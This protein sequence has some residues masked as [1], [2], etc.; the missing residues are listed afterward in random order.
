MHFYIKQC[1]VAALF[2]ASFIIASPGNA[3]APG[4]HTMTLTS[5]MGISHAFSVPKTVPS[6]LPISS[7]TP[8]SSTPIIV[9][10]PMT[11]PEEKPIV[12]DGT[13]QG[14]STE[15]DNKIKGWIKVLSAEPG[16][17]AWKKSSYVTSPLG[18]GTHAWLITLQ[19]GDK[20]TGY[21]IVSSDPEGKIELTEYG[22]GSSP[23]FS[24]ATLRDSLSQRGLLSK[25]PKYDTAA[26]RYYLG[27]LEAF[28]LIEIANKPYYFDAKSGEAL[29]DLTKLMPVQTQS[30]VDS[31]T[32][33]NPVPVEQPGKLVNATDRVT[34]QLLTEVFDPYDNAGWIID[35]PIL[36][37]DASTL[38]NLLRIDKK[39]TYTIKL[40]A[41]KALFPF[42]VRGTH[43]W[44]RGSS[45]FAVEQAGPRYVPFNRARAG[46][47]YASP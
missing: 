30:L 43:H 15:L 39:V 35:K 16:F 5:G 22:P 1:C 44:L 18:P 32:I 38:T 8:V 9:A 23:L 10:T 34:D 24:L 13:K 42:A 45:Y 29:P 28:W 3:A 37:T 7:I 26:I 36:M 25:I 33:I 12:Q 21:M 31:P 14:S 4:P 27:P 11:S 6:M 46:H 40:Y 41:Q 20:E 2:M 19:D 17:A 47:F